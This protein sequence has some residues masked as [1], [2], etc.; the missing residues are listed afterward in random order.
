MILQSFTTKIADVIYI[1]IYLERDF[2]CHMVQ[3]VLQLYAK[4]GLGFLEKVV[5]DSSI[6]EDSGVS[7]AGSS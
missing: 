6:L 3:Q 2:E 1:Y 5:A 4:E 7:S